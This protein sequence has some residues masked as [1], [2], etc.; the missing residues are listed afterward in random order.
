MLNMMLLYV[1]K[2]QQPNNINIMIGYLISSI[3]D[4]KKA[5]ESNYSFPTSH[6]SLHKSMP[7]SQE[8]I[9]ICKQE[10]ESQARSSHVSAW[11][12]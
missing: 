12:I 7:E 3:N 10:R 8:N 4:F 9:L 1:L 2:Q 11:D 6:I 5:K